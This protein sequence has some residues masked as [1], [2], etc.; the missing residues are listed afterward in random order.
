MGLTQ[1][2][3][4]SVSFATAAGT[5]VFEDLGI[6]SFDF[7]G[8]DRAEIDVTTSTD[9]SRVS[10][11]GYASPR[12]VSL[13]VLFE[14]PTLAELDAAIL[15]CAPG[16]LSVKAGVDC[17]AAAQVFSLGA[18]LMSYSISAQMDGVWEVSMEFLVDETATAENSE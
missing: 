14:D 8:G 17:A 3:G 1:F 7:Q 2:N 11:A 16:T 9:T 4:S 13:G 6:T 15:A 10:R 18:H 5:A 12:R